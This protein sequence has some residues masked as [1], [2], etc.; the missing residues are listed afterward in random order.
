MSDLDARFDAAVIVLA[1]VS[2]VLALFF[3][4][5]SFYRMRIDA[6]MVTRAELAGPAPLDLTRPDPGA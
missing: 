6:P 2:A 3:M 1:M 4:W 5:R